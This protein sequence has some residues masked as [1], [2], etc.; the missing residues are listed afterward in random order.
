[1]RV[2]DVRIGNYLTGQDGHLEDQ[3]VISISGNRIVTQPVGIPGSVSTEPI[4]KVDGHSS[5]KP[6][7]ITSEWIERLGFKNSKLVINTCIDLFHR[8][9][10]L[11]LVVEACYTVLQHIQYV[12]Q[13]QNLYFSMTGKELSAK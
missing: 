5:A 1:M 3:I 2:T 13:L 6:I 11:F 8:E 7:V 10:M 12:H 4:S 9:G